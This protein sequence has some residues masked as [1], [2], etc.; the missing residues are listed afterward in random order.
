MLDP[1]LRD[2]APV[3]N[4]QAAGLLV[5]NGLGASPS[6]ERME[7]MCQIYKDFSDESFRWLV[8][9]EPLVR[10]LADDVSDTLRSLR[11]A[12]ALRQRGTTLK[13]SGSYEIFVDRKTGNAIFALRKKDQDLILVEIPDPISAGEANLASCELTQDGDL[14][15]SFHRGNFSNSETVQRVASNAALVLTDIY[16]DVIESFQRQPPSSGNQKEWRKDAHEMH[17]LLE[18][19]SDNPEFASLVQSY[20]QQSNPSIQNPVRI[21]PSLKDVSERERLFYQ[22]AQE[23]DWD[24]KTRRRVLDRIALS[25]HKTGPIDP[26]LAFQDVKQLKIQ[27]GSTLIDAGAQPGFVYI[28]LTGSLQIRPMGGYPPFS[29]QAWMPLGITAV[30]RGSVRNATVVAEEDM[31]VLMIPQEIYLKY[32]HHTYNLGEFIDWMADERARLAGESTIDS[33]SEIFP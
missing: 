21:V 3:G 8:G 9:E 27:A 19:V 16:R 13:T 10:Q 17:I 20:F 7:L 33:P 4:E 29:I 23:L 5:Q 12:D 11:C 32:W 14:R 18:T 22:G 1:R 30:I 26:H 25:G 28:P 6:S 31:D 24:E 15:A 2:K